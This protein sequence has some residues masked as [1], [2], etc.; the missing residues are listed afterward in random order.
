MADT[1]KRMSRTVNRALT[2]DF[3]DF[4]INFVKLLWR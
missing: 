2:W 3:I 4:A 1:A